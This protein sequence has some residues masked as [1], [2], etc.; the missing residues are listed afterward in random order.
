MPFPPLDLLALAWFLVCWSGYGFYA[1][2]RAGLRPCLSNTLDVYRA[3]WMQR[4]L[5]REARIADASVVG[6]LE[7]NGAF[8][9]SSSLLIMAGILTAMGYTQQAMDVFAD[10]P[11]S[12]EHN[13][14]QWEFKLLVLLLVF[15][16]AFFKF[17][18]SMRQY[19]FVS[20]L[21]GAAPSP[22]EEGVTPAERE[23]FAQSAARVCNMAGDAFNYG[24]RAYY[25]AMA[26]LTWFLHPLLFM[27]S[28]TLVV[29]ILY[30]REFRSYALAAL[31]DGKVFPSNKTG[32]GSQP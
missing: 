31:R 9:A 28:S 18:W 12:M 1:N 10:L 13:R 26:V 22:S 17:T 8:F 21:I 5:R 4:M 16:Y 7:R 20:V 14:Q 2:H 15:V 3:D 32:R 24:L 27:L 29:A 19:N 30:R 25:F 6:T 11:F 23:A